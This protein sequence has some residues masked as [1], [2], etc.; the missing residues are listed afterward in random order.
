MRT[1]QLFDALLGFLIQLFP[2]GSAI[3]K[4]GRT[5]HAS[6]RQFD[7]P[8]ERPT[9]TPRVERR[10]HVEEHVSFIV[11]ASRG[12]WREGITG[13][14]NITSVEELQVL[15]SRFSAVCQ[16]AGYIVER[17]NSLGEFYMFAIIHTC[18]AEDKYTVLRHVVSLGKVC[19]VG[20]RP[21][22]ATHLCHCCFDF[23]ELTVRYPRKIYA[24][25]FGTKC[26][27]ELLNGN[28]VKGPILDK[29]AGHGYYLMI[30]YLPRIRNSLIFPEPVS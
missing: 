23:T 14:V 30:V 27:V 29:S 3:S 7:C 9:G 28:C 20:Q 5:T 26:R 6:R 4:L 1:D 8:Q 25:D 13:L 2:G 10:V 22:A 15:V 17:T 21:P 18:P 24:N 16:I 19:R 11:M 12:I